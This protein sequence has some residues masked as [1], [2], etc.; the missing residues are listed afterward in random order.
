MRKT[1]EKD[2]RA[3]QTSPKLSTHPFLHYV[4]LKTFKGKLQSLISFPCNS[5]TTQVYAS[6]KAMI[7]VMEECLPCLFV[8]MSFMSLVFSYGL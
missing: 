5:Y 4:T 6:H 8:L 1:Q 2:R 3:T 7:M